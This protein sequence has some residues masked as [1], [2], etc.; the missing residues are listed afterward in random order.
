MTAARTMA[1]AEISKVVLQAALRLRSEERAGRAEPLLATGVSRWRWAASHLA[2]VSGGSVLVLAAGGRGTGISYAFVVGE[3]GGIPRLVGG[4]VAYQPA[5]LVLA[6]LVMALYGLRPG[7][8][9]LV[10]AGLAVCFVVGFFGRLLSLPA[11]VQ[12]LSPFQHV[13]RPPSAAFSLAPTVALSLAAAALTA[14]G[15]VAFRRRD[16]QT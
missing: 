1:K 3:V 13:P 4:A 2:V 11:W 6:G 9:T 7:I 14:V 12:D 10:W 8:A 5:V 16:I 15:A